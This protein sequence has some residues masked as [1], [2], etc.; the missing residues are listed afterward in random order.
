MNTPTIAPLEPRHVETAAAALTRAFANDPMFN[1][2]FPDAGERSRALAALNRVPLA[3]ALRYGRAVQA[4]DGRAVAIWIRPG[5]PIS[6]TGMI[7]SGMLGM[8]FRLGFRAF[9]QFAQSNE[10]MGK[11]HKQYVP[12]P[13]WYLM[14]VGVDPDLQ[15]RGLG[16]ALI[17]EGLAPADDQQRVAYLETSDPRNVPFYRRFGFEVLESV[18]LGKDAPPGWAMRRDPRPRG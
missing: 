18:P 4:H 16:S 11:L 17:A 8:P 2:M 1:W 10:A 7:R 5:Q 9:G 14:I 15:G 3:Y 12:E 6:V 13:H